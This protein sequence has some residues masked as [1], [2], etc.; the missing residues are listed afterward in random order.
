MPLTEDK[1][2]SAKDIIGNRKKLVQWQD[3]YYEHMAER[4]PDLC[5]GEAAARTGRTHMNVQEFK[6]FTRDIRKMS[7]IADKVEALMNGANL[8]NSKGRLEQLVPL[9]RDL[10]V[11]FGKMKTQLA[12]YQEA[13]TT[14]IAENEQ[15]KKENRSMEDER[16]QRNQHDMDSGTAIHQLEQKC[17]RYEKQLA[18]IPPEV[19]AQ[20]TRQTSKQHKM[21]R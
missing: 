13:F 5:R 2:L 6:A 20:Y 3:Q 21:D 15:L 12:Q 16:R 1:R 19:L 17:Q 18:V 7:K 4:Y 10:L 9:V 11:R 8:L 14:I